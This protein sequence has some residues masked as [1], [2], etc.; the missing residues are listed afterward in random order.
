MLLSGKPPFVGNDEKAILKAV[1]SSTILYPAKYF[2]QI[3]KDGIDFIKLCLN[4]EALTRPSADELMQHSW[5]TR[6]DDDVKEP[7][8]LEVVQRLNRFQKQSRLTKICLEVVAHTLPDEKI[9]NL[10]KE[11]LKFDAKALGQISLGDFRKVLSNN[12][13]FAARDIDFIFDGIDFGNTKMIEYHEFI[14]AAVSQREISENNI[15]VAFDVMSNHSKSIGLD[16]LEEIL[17]DEDH[18]GTAE[19]IMR[20]MNYS[21]S[22]RLN[23]DDFRSIMRSGG[24]P[25]QSPYA[26]SSKKISFFPSSPKA[27]KK[28]VIGKPNP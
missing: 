21:P 3:S 17:G 23:F 9:K 6:F 14:A 7:V 28:N 18:L 5:L 4:R 22:S 15:R 11:F 8:A 16:D 2:S 10:K 1:K 24:T 12:D 27:S 13:S 19:E 25:L 26:K 20:E